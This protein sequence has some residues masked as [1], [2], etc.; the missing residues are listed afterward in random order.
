MLVD[1]QVGVIMKFSWRECAD[2]ICAVLGAMSWLYLGVYRLWKG[3]L[4]N[5]IRAQLAGNV[6]LWLLLEDLLWAFICLTLA[7]FVWFLWYILRGY[8]KGRK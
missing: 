4:M 7:G 1:G 5:L 2:G 3:P 6:T 8:F